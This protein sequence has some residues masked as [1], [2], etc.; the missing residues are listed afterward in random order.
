MSER[1]PAPPGYKYNFWGQLREDPD[2]Y[3]PP[4]Y[5]LA[6]NFITNRLELLPLYG[7]G[8]NFFSDGN[9]LPKPAKQHPGGLMGSIDNPRYVEVRPIPQEKIGQGVQ[10]VGPASG[11]DPD[12]Q[13]RRPGQTRYRPY[14]PNE[15]ALF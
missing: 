5:R 3:P 7:E 6:R 1:P 12:P 10:F 13:L 11:T 15:A 2:Y 14:D 9:A 4:G 8:V